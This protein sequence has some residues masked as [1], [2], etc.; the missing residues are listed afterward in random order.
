MKTTSSKAALFDGVLQHTGTQELS[1]MSTKVLNKP[2][3]VTGA[4]TLA[5]YRK[6]LVSFTSFPIGTFMYF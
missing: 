5:R 3:Q 1:V 4:V 6:S 2:S